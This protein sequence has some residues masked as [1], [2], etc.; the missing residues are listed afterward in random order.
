MG[1]NP[2]TKMTKF[3]TKCPKGTSKIA[4]VVDQSDDYHYLRQDSNRYWSHKPGARKATDVDAG[5]HKIW[6]PKL[7]D[8]NYTNH[9]GTLNYDIFCGYMCVPRDRRVYLRASGGGRARRIRRAA[10]RRRS[11]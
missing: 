1:D 11:R 9:E 10:T 6:D 7:A 8:L 4:L 2:H 5:G 3:E